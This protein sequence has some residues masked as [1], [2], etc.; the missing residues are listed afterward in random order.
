MAT[1]LEP[2]L[3]AGLRTIVALVLEVE[4]DSV[5]VFGEMRPRDLDNLPCPVVD[6]RIRGALLTPEQ[7]AK[8][9]HLLAEVTK[10]A[11]ELNAVRSAM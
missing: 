11:A 8:V 3:L 9:E 10:A 1:P 5:Q 2:Q 7:Q 6:V 4:E